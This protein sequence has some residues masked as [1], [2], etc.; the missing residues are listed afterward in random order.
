MNKHTRN[1]HT[2]AWQVTKPST[3]AYRSNYDAIFRKKE[4]RPVEEKPDQVP[5]DFI[6]PV[7]A[8]VYVWYFKDG[9]SREFDESQ[10]EMNV[11]GW[12]RPRNS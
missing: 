8:G 2:G 12:W 3:D 1:E 6:A 11:Q 5:N 10:I 7:P 9:K 4:E